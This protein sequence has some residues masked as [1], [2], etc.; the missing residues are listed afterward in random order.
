MST[1]DLAALIGAVV[2]AL[3]LILGIPQWRMARRQLFDQDVKRALF[4]DQPRPPS[5]DNPCLIDVLHDLRELL[6]EQAELSAVVAWHLS[7]SH[8][9]ELP[10]YLTRN[11]RR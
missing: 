5:P 1:G 10:G 7:D 9:P 2:A 4:G 8:G 6:A 3:G 11:G